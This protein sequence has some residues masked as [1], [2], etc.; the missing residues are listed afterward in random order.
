[1]DRRRG[2]K[3][4]ILLPAGNRSQERNSITAL[5][6]NGQKET[7]FFNNIDQFLPQINV[8]FAEMCDAEISLNEL[9]AAVKSVRR[10]M[11][12]QHISGNNYNNLSH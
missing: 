9:D 8:E 5:S 1:M 4:L 3:Y 6:I 7:V 10:V 11:A 2:E 12:S